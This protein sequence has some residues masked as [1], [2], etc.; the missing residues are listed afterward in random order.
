MAAA[1][2]NYR[3]R[4]VVVAVDTSKWKYNRRSKPSNEWSTFLRSH[5]R[6]A[7]EM[8]RSKTQNEISNAKKPWNAILIVWRFNLRLILLLLLFYVRWRW[9]LCEARPNR[10]T[11]Y[12]LLFLFFFFFHL[13]FKIFFVSPC[14]PLAV[15]FVSTQHS[16]AAHIIIIWI[17]VF[18]AVAAAAIATTVAVDV[19]YTFY[20]QK[21]AHIRMV[22]RLSWIEPSTHQS[23]AVHRNNNNKLYIRRR[24]WMARNKNWKCCNAYAEHA[25]M[26][27][28][29][30]YYYVRVS[31]CMRATV[32]AVLFVCA[33]LFLILFYFFVFS[34][35]FDTN[36]YMLCIL[37][38]A[39]RT[40]FTI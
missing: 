36:L 13:K 3:A 28:Y 6:R 32:C 35:G 39:K 22:D 9:R 34:T 8:P 2:V 33:T 24:T 14:F 27:H 30:Y 38:W 7:G 4:V 15:F 5:R 11:Q 1:A 25:C 26:P 19:D 21:H 29:Y 20:I 12:L 37:T 31:L 40:L 18:V 16:S 23:M 17:L 10:S